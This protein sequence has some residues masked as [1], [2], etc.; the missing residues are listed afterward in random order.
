MKCLLAAIAV[1]LGVLTAIADEPA[2]PAKVE[3]PDLRDELLK[4][5]KVDQDARAALLG[6]SMKHGL[7]GDLRAPGP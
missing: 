5:T 2:K 3:R 6:W 1:C 7:V 4:R